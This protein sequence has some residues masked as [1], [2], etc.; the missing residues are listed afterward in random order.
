MINNSDVISYHDYFGLDYSL[1]VI[2]N[3]KNIIDH[4]YVP[5]M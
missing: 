3:L 5:S 4:C 2:K 1:E